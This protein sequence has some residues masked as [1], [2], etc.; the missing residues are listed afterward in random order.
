MSREVEFDENEKCDICGKQG[1]W[2]FYGDFICP[3]CYQKQYDE[4]VEGVKE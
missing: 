4:I 3:E 1:A 2:D